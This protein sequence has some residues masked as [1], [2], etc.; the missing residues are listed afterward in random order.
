MP[1][2]ELQCG[3]KV[4]VSNSIRQGLHKITCPDCQQKTV[5]HHHNFI[6]NLPDLIQDTKL[7]ESSDADLPDDWDFGRDET[8]RYYTKKN[9]DQDDSFQSWGKAVDIVC[10][11]YYLE[12]WET[13][14][15]LPW[16]RYQ[17]VLQANE[18]LHG[19]KSHYVKKSRKNEPFYC[20]NKKI[21]K[22][23]I[24]QRQQGLCKTCGKELAYYGRLCIECRKEWDRVRYKIYLTKKI[25]NSG[26]NGGK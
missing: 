4:F 11:H 25:Q 3:H 6:H 1:S 2:Y 22:R 14:L 16:D 19:K 24:N 20:L 8:Q 13:C 18:L 5:I 10:N 7:T 9:F 15:Q 12:D 17:L 26:K 23:S 21:N